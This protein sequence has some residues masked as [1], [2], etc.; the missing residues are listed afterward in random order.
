[1]ETLLLYCVCKCCVSALVPN[2]LGGGAY[3]SAYT[4][5]ST[6]R[7]VVYVMIINKACKVNTVLRLTYSTQPLYKVPALNRQLGT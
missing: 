5:A 2:A 4:A 6:I 1:M 7:G 3:W